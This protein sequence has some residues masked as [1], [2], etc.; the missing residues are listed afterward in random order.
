MALAKDMITLDKMCCSD[1]KNRKKFQ[2]SLEFS[3]QFVGCQ[4]M[5]ETVLRQS[6]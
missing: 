2:W 5:L 4:I 6:V 3:D 1:A